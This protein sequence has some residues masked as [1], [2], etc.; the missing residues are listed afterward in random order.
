MTHVRLARSLL[1]LDETLSCV[2]Q[3]SR[4]GFSEAFLFHIFSDF[5]IEFVEKRFVDDIA[6]GGMILISHFARGV[7]WGVKGL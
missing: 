3:N 5:L 1:L 4:P 7:G 6:W 2:L